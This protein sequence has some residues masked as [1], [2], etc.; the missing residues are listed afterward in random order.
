[1][2]CKKCGKELLS[3][4]KFCI[5]CGNDVGVSSQVA[6]MDAT[7]QD[8][9]TADKPV[10]QTSRTSEV[11]MQDECRNA[12]AADNDTSRDFVDASHLQ[13]DDSSVSSSSTTSSFTTAKQSLANGAEKFKKFDNKKKYSI[14]G[15]ACAAVVLLLLVVFVGG[16]AFGAVSTDA[17]RTAFEQSSILSKG[18]VSQ[19]YTNE[20]AYHIKSFKIDSQEDL[21][22]KYGSE[23]R[24]L[25]QTM[26]GSEDLKSVICSGTITNDS[27]ETDF[28]VEIH[29]AKIGGNWV[30]ID[31][32][33]TVS[34]STKPLKGPDYVK[35]SASTSTSSNSNPLY[36]DYSS[37]LEESDGVYTST[38]EQTV[39]YEFWFA[40]DTAKSIQKFTFDGK[41]GWKTVGDEEQT[42]TNT[43]WNL[44]SKVFGYEKVESLSK[45][46]SDISLSFSEISDSAAKATYKIHY[47]P[48]ANSSS[49]YSTYNEVNLNGSASGKITHDFGKESFEFTLEDTG[50]S[51]TFSGNFYGSSSYEKHNLNCNVKTKSDYITYSGGN[52]SKLSYSYITLE[53]S[54]NT[55][56]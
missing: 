54:A 52:G 50:Q 25:A 3:D 44:P 32:P 31:T 11:G 24:S 48:S 4:A 37:S 12:N 36:S 56:A 15:G 26:Y 42:D 38:V 51:V 55:S 45:G 7:N 40:K 47:K 2:K 1:M 17:A 35:K 34:S 9:R 27:F 19:N 53:E 8:S 18:I 6:N 23:Y 39:T 28:N 30:T 43:T 13:H 22:A 29:F 14:V 33:E 46:T 49:S 5:G 21:L 20:S 10:S 16:N 41:S